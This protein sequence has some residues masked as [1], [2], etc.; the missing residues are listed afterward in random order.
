MNPL[1]PRSKYS[2]ANKGQT[3]ALLSIVLAL[4][5]AYIESVNQFISTIVI[6]VFR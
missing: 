4:A 3:I 2:G 1:T 5:Y 6:A